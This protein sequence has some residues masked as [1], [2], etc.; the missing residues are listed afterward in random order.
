M[1]M[2]ALRLLQRERREDEVVGGGWWLW[3]HEMERK[4]FVHEHEVTLRETKDGQTERNSRR[5]IESNDSWT[6][7]AVDRS[8]RS[9]SR[10]EMKK[11]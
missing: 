8:R 2:L 4:G 10:I 7:A 3:S 1:V 6:E 9:R 5:S 11:T